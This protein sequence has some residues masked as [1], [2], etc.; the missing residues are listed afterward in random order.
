MFKVLAKSNMIIL[1]KQ[2]DKFLLKQDFT[3]NLDT[4]TSLVLKKRFSK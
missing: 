4:F 3:I 2:R 1:N